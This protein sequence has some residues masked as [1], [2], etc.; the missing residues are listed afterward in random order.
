MNPGDIFNEL[1]SILMQLVNKKLV[2]THYEEGRHYE[3]NDVNIPFWDE[4]AIVSFKSK[5][6]EPEPYVHAVLD[7]EGC[8]DYGYVGGHEPHFKSWLM[9]PDVDRVIQE[10]EKTIFI[11]S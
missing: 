7:I 6:V 5:G 11:L 9:R 8:P 3:V 4:T 2:I 10:L 1:Y